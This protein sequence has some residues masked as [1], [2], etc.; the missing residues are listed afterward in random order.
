MLDRLLSLLRK[1]GTHTLAELAQILRTTPSMVEAMLEDLSRRGYLRTQEGDCAGQ[2]GGCPLGATC[3]V[4]GGGRIWTM[5]G[6]THNRAGTP[7]HR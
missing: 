6:E 2:C 7:S 1:G 5:L 4:G 3:T